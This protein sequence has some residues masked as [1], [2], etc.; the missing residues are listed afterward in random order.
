MTL[1][2]RIIGFAIAFWSV[3][4]W[5]FSR[6]I[7]GSDAPWGVL[8][9]L[10]LAATSQK[11]VEVDER[12]D[13]AVPFFVFLY[14]LS[15]PFL[16]NLLR[17]SI[18]C[19]AVGVWISERRGVGRFH[20]GTWAL[21]GMVLPWL[22]S[23]NF[24]LNYPLRVVTTFLSVRFL[25]L[26]GLPIYADGFA[27]NW[28]PVSVW[29][30]APCAGVRMLWVGVFLAS[31]LA[32]IFRLK[33]WAT[34]ALLGIGLV[35]T[36]LGNVARAS[37]VFYL[38]AGL[39]DAPDWFHPVSGVV[40][41]SVVTIAVCAAAF[42][43]RRFQVE[44]LPKRARRPGIAF[45]FAVAAAALV[46]FVT[47]PSSAG[48]SSGF[49]GFPETFDG[50]TLHE[51]PIDP[52]EAKYVDGFPGKIGTYE[53]AS[54]DLVLRWISSPTRRLHSAV[55]C[56]RGLGFEVKPIDTDSDWASYEATK[57]D[58][59]KVETITF[60]ERIVDADGEVFEDV[61]A[62]YWAATFGKSTGPWWNVVRVHKS[63]AQDER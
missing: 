18:A 29:V 9:L 21:V 51:R 41:F 12:R 7:D 5:W 54:Y 3:G 1:F 16:P 56:Y 44:A 55:D 35:A 34:I 22:A 6:T 47:P 45:F 13:L 23:L 17:G 33:N 14:A 27:L 24:F 49:T 15:F 31:A 43:L 39:I 60:E 28:G 25:R 46:P 11:S 58:G 36:V 57:S 32:Y 42:W 53:T 59:A 38:E 8:A 50:E 20:F 48:T 2:V 63:S 40:A 19:L 37:A 26:S 30:D 52:R 62:W 4:Q 10:L 61:G